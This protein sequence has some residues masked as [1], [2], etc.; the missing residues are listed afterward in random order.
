MEGTDTCIVD[1]FVLFGVIITVITLG[2]YDTQGCNR[3]KRGSPNEL[4]GIKYD[5]NGQIGSL[6]SP[7]S[8]TYMVL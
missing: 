6:V 7:L 1:G 5:T 2:V 3:A 4:F 8:R